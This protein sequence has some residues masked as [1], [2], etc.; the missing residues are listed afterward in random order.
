MKTLLALLALAAVTVHAG[1]PR[2]VP[3]TV[4]I[5]ATVF[6]ENPYVTNSVAGTA[7]AAAATKFK[8]TTASTLLALAQAEFFNGNYS[9]ST[10]PSGAKLVWLNYYDQPADSHFIVTDKNLVEL[11]DVSDVLA[12][13]P[14]SAAVRSGTK[15][16]GTPDLVKNAHQN[17]IAALVYDDT[18]S[19]GGQSIT[20]AGLIQASA[21]DVVAGSGLTYKE[22]LAANLNNGAGAGSYYGSKLYL[23]GSVTSGGTATITF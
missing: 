22:T 6:A 7:T 19:G 18:D 12:L 20:I 14:I 3:M 23:T 8:I 2:V 13:L 16:I 4:S 17:Y 5:S 21:N 10:F 1:T 15:T 11:C 9:F